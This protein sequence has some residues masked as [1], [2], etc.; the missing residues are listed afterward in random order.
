MRTRRRRERGTT[1]GGKL[2]SA[3][4]R[5]PWGPSGH[6]SPQS[7]QG[8]FAIRPPAP[9]ARGA[10]GLRVSARGHCGRGLLAGAAAELCRGRSAPRGETRGGARSDASARDARSS[11]PSSSVVRTGLCNRSCGWGRSCPRARVHASAALK[12]S[13]QGW[14]GA[15]TMSYTCFVTPSTASTSYRFS[16]CEIAHATWR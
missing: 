10:A 13:R 9:P 16:M 12:F 4:R 5:K 11:C 7:P 8:E 2:L 15:T 14:A 3:L 6:F 1:N